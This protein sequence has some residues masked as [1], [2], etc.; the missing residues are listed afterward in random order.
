LFWEVQTIS[1]LSYCS[2]RIYQTSIRGTEKAHQVESQIK[3]ERKLGQGSVCLADRFLDVLTS[4][5]ICSHKARK[6]VEESKGL[7]IF[8]FLKCFC[9]T[10][11]CYIAEGGQTYLGSVG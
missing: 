10:L 9:L 1:F 5:E 11:G 7:D 6:V 4:F 3:V 8:S 2:Q